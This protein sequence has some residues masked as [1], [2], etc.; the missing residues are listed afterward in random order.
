MKSKSFSAGALGVLLFFAGQCFPVQAETLPEPD[1]KTSIVP[2]PDRETL[3]LPAP[4]RETL[5]LSAPDRETSTISAPQGRETPAVPGQDQKTGPAPQP[6]RGTGEQQEQ[7]SAASVPA[8]SPAASPVPARPSAASVPVRS[9][10]VSDRSS[11]VSESPPSRNPPDRGLFLGAM[12]GLRTLS[13]DTDDTD[14]KSVE[15]DGSATYSAGLFFGA[16]FGRV[17]AQAEVILSEDKGAIENLSGFDEIS[18]R[19][20]L[21]PLIV[22]GDFL[23]GPVVLQPLAGLYFNVA[24]GDLTLGGTMGG[25]EPY[26]S[27]PVGLMV[28]GDLGLR[29]GRNRIFLD[30][31]YAVDLGKT[32]VGNDP[33][34]AWRRSAFMFNLGYQFYLWRKT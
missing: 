18:G 31:R 19:S 16:D 23:L 9:P 7:P 33:M 14:W 34:T 21:I 13:Y 3:I 17:I 10:A 27:P 6:R 8:R 22:K 11:A 30:L 24:L 1:R 29:F 12:A 15:L 2:E 4:D 5:I 26:A 25:D 32:A 20:L 28:G